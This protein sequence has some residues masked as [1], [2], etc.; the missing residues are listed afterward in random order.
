[1]T[2]FEQ[3]NCLKSMTIIVDTREQQSDRAKK[4]YEAFSVPYRRQKLDFG[5]YSA[6][7][8]MPDGNEQTINAAIE[9]KANLEELSACF[10]RDRRRFQNEFERAKIAEASMYL[11][12]E[13][14]SWENLMN[15]KYDTGF[16]PKAFM[17]SMTAWIVRYDIKPVFCKSESSGKIIKEILYRELKER[18][19]RG[20]YG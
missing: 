20:E 10:T 6:C 1:M 14:A 11:L 19:E 2:V 3:E 13:N 5:D 8:M 16:N 9:R 12:V 17:A 4:R 7:F 18:L 15:G